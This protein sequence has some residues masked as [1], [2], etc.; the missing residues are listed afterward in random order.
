MIWGK[1]IEIILIILAF[2]AHIIVV[3]V[4]PYFK[5]RDSYEKLKE[6]HEIIEKESKD[7]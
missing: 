7:E 2:I 4:I 6:F 5:N 1:I 3:Y